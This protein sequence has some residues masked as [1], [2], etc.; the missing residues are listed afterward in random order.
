MATGV[1]KHV[2]CVYFDMMWKFVAS[3]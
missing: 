2:G 3:N 1:L